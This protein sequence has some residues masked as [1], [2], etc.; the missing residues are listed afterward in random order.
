MEYN[1]TT[2]NQCIIIND[3]LLPKSVYSVVKIANGVRIANINLDYR[4]TK[5]DGEQVHSMEELYEY[6]RVH[7]FNNSGGGSVISG[8]QSV[9]GALVDN[10]DAMNPKVNLPKGGTDN[11]FLCGS[12][13]WKEIKSGGVDT[14]VK[15]SVISSSDGSFEISL[16]QGRFSKPPIVMLTPYVNHIGVQGFANL[17]EVTEINIKGTVV[18]KVG[19]GLSVTINYLITESHP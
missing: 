17:I 9:S 14:F 4:T 11:T 2:E 3:S 12:G 16:E 10:T 5:I 15:G 8:I 19:T 1:I 18:N 6:F 7:G 13:T